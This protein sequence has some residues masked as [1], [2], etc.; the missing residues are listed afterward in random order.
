VGRLSGE[1]DTPDLAMEQAELEQIIEKAR[2][3][4]STRL[5]L[6]SGEIINTLPDSIVTL[7][8]L[9]QL[10]LN[11]RQLNSLPDAIGDLSYA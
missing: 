8:H 7:S 2:L 1:L 5:D 4:R 3:N 10:Y 6:G 9:T 11:F